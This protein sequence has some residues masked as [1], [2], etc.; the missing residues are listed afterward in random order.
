MKRWGDDMVTVFSLHNYERAYNEVLARDLDGENADDLPSANSLLAKIHRFEWTRR[1]QHAFEDFNPV[2]HYPEPNG[3]NWLHN[4]VDDWKDRVVEILAPLKDRKYITEATLNPRIKSADE[5][6]TLIRVIEA[7]KLLVLGNRGNWSHW[8]E[9]VCDFER[10]HPHSAVSWLPPIFEHF[11]PEVLLKGLEASRR[12]SSLAGTQH[13]LAHRNTGSL[14]K[15]QIYQ[16]APR[17]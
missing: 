3:F 1:L 12:H 11:D 6:N 16:T 5:V 9:K 13:T 10:S 2:T 4:A 7:L 15:S 14:R 8:D 17:I